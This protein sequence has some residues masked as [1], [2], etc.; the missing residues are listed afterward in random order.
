[1]TV[2]IKAK[3]LEFILE[4]SRSA[5]PREFLGLLR[6]EEGVVTEVLVAPLPTFEIGSSS[7]RLD[8]KPLDPSIVGSIHSH[9]GPPLPS[10]ADMHFFSQFGKVHMI[11][12]YPF[13]PRDIWI[14]GGEQLEIVK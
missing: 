4:A 5:Y 3:A 14:L 1:M 7:T 6:A 12:G 11:V 10:R 8:M 2:K 9:P 13:T